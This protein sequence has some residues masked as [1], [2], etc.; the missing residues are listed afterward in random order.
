M[1][2]TLLALVLAASVPMMPGTASAKEPLLRPFKFLKERRTYNQTHDHDE[3][4]T[5]S[6]FREFKKTGQKPA[7][8]EPRA[9]LVRKINRA[10]GLVTRLEH[11]ATLPLPR[12]GWGTNA[13]E[14]AFLGSFSLFNRTKAAISDMQAYS[15]RLTSEHAHMQG[16]PTK[17]YKARAVAAMERNIDLPFQISGL[18]DPNLASDRSKARSGYLELKLEK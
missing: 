7:E 11:D 5:M 1:R 13:H 16:A 17:G 8:L 10:N 3:R 6:Q 12:D 15:D 4:M 2:K 14:E 18:V 9:V